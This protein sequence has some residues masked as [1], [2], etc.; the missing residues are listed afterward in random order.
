MN[1]VCSRIAVAG[2]SLASVF[3]LGV[4]PG[5]AGMPVPAPIVG[6]TGPAGIVIVGVAYGGYWLVRR[7]RSRG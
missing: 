5:W 2:F 1:W 7:Y 4:E 6:L 3:L